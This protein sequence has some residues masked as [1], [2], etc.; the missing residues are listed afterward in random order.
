MQKIQPCLWFNDQ[1]EDAAKLYTSLFRNSGIRRVV[2][3]GQAAAHASGQPAGSV[4]T[5]DFELAGL[6]FLGLNGGPHFT[7]NPAISLF[8]GCE[9]QGEIRALWEALAHKVRMQLQNYPFAEMY[10][11]CEDRFGVHWQLIL[12]PRAQK[13]SPALLFANKRYGK[14]EEAIQFYV[15]TFPGAQI[16]RIA[17]DEKTG[18]VL[19]SVF[20]LDGSELIAMEGPLEH[21][22]DFSPAFS[23]ILNC[24]SQAEI[25]DLW[26]KLSAVPAAEQCGWLCDRYGVSW[27]IVPKD[28]GKMLG[29]ADPA[30]RDRLMSA[31]LKMKKPD[32]KVLEEALRG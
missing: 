4:M 3:Y 21:Q 18:A 17:R 11:W 27:Q 23:F 7:L 31:I 28:W 32:Q 14:A 8:V 6:P 22:F 20:S 2:R 26:R 1:A 9:S 15:S 29:A 16:E 19:H 30:A 13:V 24:D 10:G 12:G 25:D 5:V